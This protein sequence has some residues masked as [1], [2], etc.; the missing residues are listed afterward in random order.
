GV[1]S[2]AVG[3]LG[4]GGAHLNVRAHRGLPGR[5]KHWRFRLDLPPG[6]SRDAIESGLTVVEDPDPQGRVAIHVPIRAADE[7]IGA[8]QLRADAAMPLDGWAHEILASYADYIAALVT[9]LPARPRPLIASP[10]EPDATD[11]NTLLTERQQEVLHM[12]VD[13]GA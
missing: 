3:L 6:P 4:D 2:V 11:L 8:L 7:S 12:L 10:L 5:R 13:G 9:N 1:H